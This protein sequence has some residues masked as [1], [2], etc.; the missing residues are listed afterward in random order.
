VRLISDIA[1][2]IER[3]WS[4]IGKGV[5]YAALPYLRAMQSL[6][7]IDEQYGADSGR[8]IVAYFL[9]NAKTFRGEDARRLKAELME[10]L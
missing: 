10:M 9:S 5:N 1:F 7:T 8:S 6:T 4:K 2:E 3:I